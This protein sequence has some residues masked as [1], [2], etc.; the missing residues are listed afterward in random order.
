VLGVHLIHPAHG[1]PAH[2]QKLTRERGPLAAL[3]HNHRVEQF[4][5]TASFEHMFDCVQDRQTTPLVKAA[6]TADLWMKSRLGINRRD[7]L[8]LRGSRCP[9]VKAARG[10]PTGAEL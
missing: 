2:R 1:E 3:G 10:V 9:S 7:G 8:S 4:R 6:Q 5:I